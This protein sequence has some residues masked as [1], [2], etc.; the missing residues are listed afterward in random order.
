MYGSK[1]E[2]EVKLFITE[3]SYPDP[4]ESVMLALSYADKTE[5]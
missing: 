5:E 2:V 3:Y 1:N 4:S